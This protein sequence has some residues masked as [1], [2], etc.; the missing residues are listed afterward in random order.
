MQLIRELIVSAVVGM[1]AASV[2]AWAYDWEATLFGLAIGSGCLI[3]TIPYFLLT[4]L[5]VSLFKVIAVV[6]LE[7]LLTNVLFLYYF[8]ISRE[9]EAEDQMVLFVAL[10]WN[11]ACLSTFA[12]LSWAGRKPNM[13]QR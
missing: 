8:S 10:I 2:S 9:G 1:V 3:I 5:G 7:Y 11:V 12:Y 6:A 13:V 4:S